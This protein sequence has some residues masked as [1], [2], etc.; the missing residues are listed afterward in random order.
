[1]T[2][3]PNDT[4]VAGMGTNHTSVIVEMAAYDCLPPA[5]RRVLCV[6]P[7]KLSAV[8]LAAAIAEDGVEAV[9]ADLRREWSAYVATLGWIPLTS[10]LYLGDLP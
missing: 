5:V 3:R 9:I 10:D 6:A 4:F 8:S 1:M 2:T 7:T